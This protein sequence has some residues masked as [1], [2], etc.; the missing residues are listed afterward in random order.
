M[1]I[2]V[3]KSKIHRVAVTEA[4]LDYIGSITIDEYLMDASGL[5]EFEKVQVVNVNNGERLE[6]YVIKGKRGSGT[7]CLNGPAARKAM[8]GDIVVIISYATM[9]PDEAKTHQP[10]M[11][12]PKAGNLL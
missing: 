11:V 1:Q 9:T 3:L 10:M 2:Q 6:T 7:I 4:N 5:I 8:A 12:F